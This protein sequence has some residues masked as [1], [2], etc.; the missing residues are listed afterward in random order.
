MKA[1]F[2][3]IALTVIAGQATA[4]SCMRPD[5]VRTFERVSEDTDT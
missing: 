4:L 1:A 3:A 5:A 2:A